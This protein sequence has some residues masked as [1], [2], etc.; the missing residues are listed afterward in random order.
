MI[1]NDPYKID[2][3]IYRDALVLQYHLFNSRQIYRDP[4][5]PLYHFII[6]YF[7]EKVMGKNCYLYHL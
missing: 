1:K 7:I 4:I 3:L 2:F 5:S 6:K